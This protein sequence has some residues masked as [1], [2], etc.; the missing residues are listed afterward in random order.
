[1]SDPEKPNEEGVTFTFGGKEIK[2]IILEGTVEEIKN[3]LHNFVM[4]VLK[5]E[6]EETKSAPQSMSD[7]EDEESC[8]WCMK[9]IIR[10]R[11]EEKSLAAIFQ[12]IDRGR[13]SER[14][15]S[16]LRHDL[17]VAYDVLMRVPSHVDAAHEEIHKLQM[18]IMDDL[19]A[20]S[21]MKAEIRDLKAKLG[22]SPGDPIPYNA[23]W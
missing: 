13:H 8:R 10:T 21:Q 15:S 7:R 20:I 1:M 19:L 9:N 23:Y 14:A 16:E 5:N 2:P 18:Q 3:Q 11:E 4:D 6:T 12:M 17:Q 22:I